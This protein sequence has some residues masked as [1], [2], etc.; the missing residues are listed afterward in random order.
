MN[1]RLSIEP[2]MLNDTLIADLFI[3]TVD[4]LIVTFS[5]IGRDPDD[6]PPLEFAQT[7]VGQGTYHRIRQLADHLSSRTHCFRQ[8]FAEGPPHASTGRCDLS[9][10]R[11][12]AVP[13]TRRDGNCPNIYPAERSHT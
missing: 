8:S 2:I 9:C 1:A 11:T 3:G 5:V 7:A 6:V 10:D 4:R 12:Y 13:R